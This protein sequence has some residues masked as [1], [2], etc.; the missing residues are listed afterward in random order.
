M[1]PTGEGLAFRDGRPV[2]V[3][4]AWP[5]ERVVATLDA[6]ERRATV[7]EW[8]TRDPDRIEPPC[9]LF[10]RCGGCDWM[11]AA[12]ELRHRLHREVLH[13]VL[14]RWLH[15]LEV[16]AVGEPLG[17]RVRARLAVRVR[18]TARVGYRRA[19]SRSLIELG[20]CV[21]LDERLQAVIPS[22]RDALHGGRG[23]GEAQIALGQGG[24][25]VVELRFQGE[26]SPRTFAAFDAHV[27]D[28]WA[29]ARIWLDDVREPAV[30][31]DPRPVIPGADGEPLVLAAGGFGQPSEAAGVRLG[32][33]VA[34]WAS[35]SPVQEAV[36]LFAG[37]GT[38]TVALLPHVE[39]LVAV[40]QSEA[41]V[42][43]LRENVE[44]RGGSAKAVVGDADRR[45]LSRG[46]DLVV[47]DPPRR[48]APG[49]VE[50][51]LLA[52][53]RRILYVACNPVAL[54]KDL[55]GLAP[56]YE[57]HRHRA[58]ALFPQT[59]HVEV[60]VELHRRSERV[61]E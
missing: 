14:G 33:V 17:Y 61:S 27:G 34:A 41:S 3:A 9:S 25:P 11:A 30:F 52:R 36:E 7:Q 6:S 49:A 4:G 24:R 45:K 43:C 8:L 1:A 39:R 13:D 44:A 15:D 29:G 57:V 18:G 31:G 60:V 51:L 53:P 35:A 19:R 20:R 54:A 23:D 47:L 5:G 40:E 46:L 12:D 21:V 48:G 38:L 42:R 2:K 37:S 10:D 55:E 28:D 16:E 50:Q 59:S 32:A 22:L 56:R 58:F 26:L